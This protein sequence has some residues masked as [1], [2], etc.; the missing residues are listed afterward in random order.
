MIIMIIH[1]YITPLPKSGQ[2]PFTELNTKIVKRTKISEATTVKRPRKLKTYLF[3]NAAKV[4][5]L[6]CL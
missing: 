1:F 2:V 4:K 5:K 6:D 3:S